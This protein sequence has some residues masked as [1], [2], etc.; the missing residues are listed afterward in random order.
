VPDASDNGPTRRRDAERNREAILGAAR[1]A[2]AEAGVAVG[3]DHIARRAGVGPATLYRHFPSKGALVDAV[4]ERR[5]VALCET[6]QQSDEIGDPAEALRDLFHRIVDAQMRDR[7]FRDL[8]AWADAESVR[9]VPALAKLG[10]MI[11]RIVERAHA[12]GVLRPD[13]K[14]EDVLVL[15]MAFECVSPSA[16]KVAPR[17]MHRLADV[18]VDGLLGTRTPLDG[19][20]VPFEQLRAVAAAGS[21]LPPRADS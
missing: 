16:G 1:E 10:E 15:Q 3:V 5:A 4:L 20:P 7:S 2:F 11:G 21:G 12:A 6:V 18:V 17:S 13:V 19:E 8:L 14:L 9:D